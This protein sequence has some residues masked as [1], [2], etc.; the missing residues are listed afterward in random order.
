MDTSR[1][2]GSY[3]TAL[4]DMCKNLA[5]CIL[6]GRCGED[7]YVGK[8]T[9]TDNTVIDYMIGSPFILGRVKKY[10]CMILTA[11]SQISTVLL[12]WCCVI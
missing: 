10:M 7:K 11:C 2:Y 6:Y 8:I 9:S 5:L 12:N 1:D 4:L 3:G